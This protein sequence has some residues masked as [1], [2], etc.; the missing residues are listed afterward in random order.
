MS[1]TPKPPLY[2]IRCATCGAAGRTQHQQLQW[3]PMYC[4]RCAQPEETH[5]A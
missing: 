4:A 2:T 5:H 1:F 3:C